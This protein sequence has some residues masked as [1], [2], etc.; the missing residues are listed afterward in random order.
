MTRQPIPY[1]ALRQFVASTLTSVGLSPADADTGATALA[2]TDAWGVFTH[3]TK[4]LAGYLRRLKTGALRPRGVPAV[5][6]Q[7][8]AWA[9]VDG[10]SSLGHV[11]S[12]F[13]MRVAMEKA[14]A[15]GIAYVGVRNSC[16]FGAAGY[17]TWLA[18]REG[19]IG[20]SMAN[21]IPSVAAPGSRGAI[22]GSN[23]L[24][25]AIPAGRR[26]PVLLDMST[27][28]VAGGKVYAAKMR[29]EPIPNTWLLGPD[30]R[31]TTDPSCYPEA[32]TLTP[33]AGHKGYGI[34][35]LIEA[36]SG[37]LTG[38]EITWKVGSWMWD[39]GQR[40]TQH[41]AAFIVIDPRVLTSPEQFG[42]RMEGLIDEIHAS[43]R[44]DGVDRLLV[45]GELEWE[46]Y[47]RAMRDG[48]QLPVDVVENVGKAAEIAGVASPIRS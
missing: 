33:A 11:T 18:A 45:P 20:I 48:I 42:R 28:T 1:E 41:G 46:T 26:R 22:L 47:D 40:P 35:L 29:G 3:G 32:G 34:A 36:L 13:A 37:V 12:V 4:C 14:R 6:A 9:V 24:S 25:Y 21:D 8:G 44:A 15:Q 17:Y 2:T 5:A 19:L 38:A 31:P 10:D 27:A 30:G 16:H 43:P 7:G 23:P 39:D